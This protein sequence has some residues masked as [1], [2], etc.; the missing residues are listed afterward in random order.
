MI[1]FIVVAFTLCSYIEHNY[2]RKSCEVIQVHNGIV[3]VVDK[4]GNVWEFEGEGYHKGDTVN[5][6]MNDN[7]TST[8]C[9][10]YIKKVK[11]VK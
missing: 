9:D 10:D 3:A 7:C 6:H 11:K 2:T 5:L 4:G 1:G 8:I